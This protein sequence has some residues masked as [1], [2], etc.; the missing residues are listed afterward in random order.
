MRCK[1]QFGIEINL[2]EALIV[3]LQEHCNGLN[4]E[5]IIEVFRPPARYVEVPLVIEN[6]VYE[7]MTYEKGVPINKSIP[8]VF[9][10][11]KLQVVTVNKQVP[12]YIEKPVQC[13]INQQVPIEVV[14]E[15]LL[16]V[17]TNRDVIVERVVETSKEVPTIIEK[18][19]PSYI[20]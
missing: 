15:R 3:M 4:I 16:E 9:P 12:V 8:H 14:T 19:V 18:P 7:S 10:E 11:Q 5:Q 1:T 20:R 13:I 17:P 2:D 6:K